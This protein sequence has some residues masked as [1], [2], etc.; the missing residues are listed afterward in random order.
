MLL[1]INNEKRKK[2]LRKSIKQVSFFGTSNVCICSCC[3][4]FGRM[5]VSKNRVISERYL[6]TIACVC[7]VCTIPRLPHS[8]QECIMVF[9]NRRMALDGDKMK[10]RSRPFAGWS[11]QRAMAPAMAMAMRE[12]EVLMDVA[13]FVEEDRTGVVVELPPAVV[14]VAEFDAAPDDTAMVEDGVS[15]VETGVM[16]G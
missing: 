13:P 9:E 4:C 16:T 10:D 5:G 7:V 8:L 1:K 15:E 14:G 3:I 2:N 6:T 11:A 12:R